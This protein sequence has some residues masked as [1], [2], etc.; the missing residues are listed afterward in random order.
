MNAL[1]LAAGWYT[2]PADA[3]F[4]RFWNGS[5][6]SEHVKP[7]PGLPVRLQQDRRRAFFRARRRIA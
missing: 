2:D 5:D 4:L 3:A 1:T 7:R 6:W